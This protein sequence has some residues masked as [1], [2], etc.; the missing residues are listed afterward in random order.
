MVSINKI[1]D[2]C[3]HFCTYPLPFVVSTCPTII[4]GLKVVAL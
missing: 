4:L 3:L 2:A 1:V